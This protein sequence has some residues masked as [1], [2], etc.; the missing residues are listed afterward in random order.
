[1]AL[2]TLGIVIGASAAANPIIIAAGLGGTLANGIPNLLS[3]YS[4]EGVERYKELRRI[5]EAMVSKDMKVSEPERQVSKKAPK[6]GAVDGSATIIGGGIPILPYLFLPTFDAM[7]VAIGVV[8]AAVSVIG[9]YLGKLSKRNILLSASKMGV[10][11]IAVAGVVYLIQS[12][13]VPSQQ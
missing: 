11:C 7:P 13:I 2:S 8:I 9:I 3:A 5:E 12:L 4:A 6:I 1:M 10:L